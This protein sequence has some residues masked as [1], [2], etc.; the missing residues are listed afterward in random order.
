MEGDVGV[1]GDVNVTNTPDVNVVNEPTV[2]VANVPGVTVENT[3][4]VNVQNTPTV[5][6]T[7]SELDPVVVRDVSDD[8]ES[9]ELVRGALTSIASEDTLT[10]PPGRVVTDIMADVTFFE[11]DPRCNLSIREGSGGPTIFVTRLLEE[12]LHELHLESGL[13]S[14]MAGL[15]LVR[16]TTDCRFNLLYTGYVK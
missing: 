3:P 6:V 2:N 10:V 8:A 7:S 12:G 16:I 15:D 4:G 14:G 5:E 9:R 11:G 1:E 13:D